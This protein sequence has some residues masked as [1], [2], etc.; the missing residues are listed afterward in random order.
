[1]S[2]FED[3]AG[4]N[5]NQPHCQHSKPAWTSLGKPWMGLRLETLGVYFTNTLHLAQIN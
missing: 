2:H 4:L 3:N 5:S 1:M